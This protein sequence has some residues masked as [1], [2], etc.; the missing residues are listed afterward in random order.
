MVAVPCSLE[1]FPQWLDGVYTLTYIVYD[2]SG[3]EIARK[4]KKFFIDCNAKNCLKSLIK[5]LLSDCID[6]EGSDPRVVMLRSKL[7]AAWNQFDECLYECAQETID[8]V[9]K[10]CKNFCLDCD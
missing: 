4:T 8:S 3:S 2:L 5:T 6:C 1:N 9:N 7:E 10:Q